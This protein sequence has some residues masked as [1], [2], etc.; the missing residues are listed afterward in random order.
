MPIKSAAVEV[1]LGDQSLSTNITKTG[2]IYGIV[3][4]PVKEEHPKLSFKVIQ[5]AKKAKNEGSIDDEE[6]EVKEPTVGKVDSD[7]LV[8]RV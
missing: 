3:M 5:R 6:L 2:L 8:S 7:C 1:T 4:F